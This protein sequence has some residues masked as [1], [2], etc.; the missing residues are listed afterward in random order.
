MFDKDFEM[1]DYYIIF[2]LANGKIEQWFMN[3]L[4]R[5]KVYDKIISMISSK[6]L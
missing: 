3:K 5:D 1:D 2:Y 4:E 6:E